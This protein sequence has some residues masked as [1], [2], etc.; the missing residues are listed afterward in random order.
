MLEVPLKIVSVNINATLSVKRTTFNCS[1]SHIFTEWY[2]SQC[3]KKPAVAT[4]LYGMCGRLYWK[5]KMKAVEK[6]LSELPV[7]PAVVLEHVKRGVGEQSSPSHGLITRLPVRA[8]QLLY[9]TLAVS[10]QLVQTQLSANRNMQIQ[11]SRLKIRIMFGITVK[12]RKL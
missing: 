3:K 10:Q 7:V 8:T 4:Q 1:L 2:L 9:Y 6:T 11:V 5:I 12:E